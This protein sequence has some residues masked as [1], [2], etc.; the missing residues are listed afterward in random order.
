MI[1]TPY[2]HLAHIHYCIPIVILLEWIVISYMH[3]IFNQCTVRY[4]TA[5]LLGLLS[6]FNVCVG[7]ESSKNVKFFLNAMHAI[8][9]MRTNKLKACP[10]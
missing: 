9:S 8:I 1:I 10:I 2:T 4:T 5:Q 7:K 6:R 3:Y